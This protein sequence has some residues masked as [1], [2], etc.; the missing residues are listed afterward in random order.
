VVIVGVTHL[1]YPEVRSD[2][3]VGV[4]WTVLGTVVLPPVQRRL[5]RRGVELGRW[6]AW[7]ALLLGV[8]AVEQLVVSLDGPP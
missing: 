1:A 3:L 6:T 4:G 7:V 2:L 8:V 5:R